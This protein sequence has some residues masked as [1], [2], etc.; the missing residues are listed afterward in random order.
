MAEPAEST[1]TE[2]ATPE[3]T[4]PTTRDQAGR[5]KKHKSLGTLSER[6][7]AKE[8]AEESAKAIGLPEDEP[9]EEAE[10]EADKPAEAAAEPKPGEPPKPRRETVET[11]P[12]KEA[13]E[14]QLRNERLEF[15]E[16]K[17]KQREGI[18][19]HLRN[20]RQKHEQQLKA[21]RDAFEKERGEFSPRVEKGEKVLK[22]ME[23]ADYEGLAKEAGY[24]DWDKFQAHVLGTISDPNYRETRALRRELEERKA[25]EKADAEAAEKKTKAEQE[26]H[27]RRTHAQQQTQAVAAH[28][29]GLSDAMAKSS[30]RLVQHMA[31]DPAFLNAVFEIQR[32]NYDPSTNSTVTPEQ[33]CRMALRGAPRTL[34]EEV[35]QLRDRLNKAL[36][37]DVPAAPAAAAEP[38]KP[39]A[40]KTGVVPSTA[41]VEPAAAGK[42]PGGAKGKAWRDYAAKKMEEQA[43]VEEAE[44]LKRKTARR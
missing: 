8:A 11:P 3:S 18:E 10:G 28:K 21:E 15:S 26:E 29:K 34:K 16:W 24:E 14:A 35:S 39:K 31:D 37:E 7:A 9:E 36:G 2:T 32:Q 22:L 42:W 41:T 12:T 33:A 1:T 30:D 40:S 25:K 23:S 17:R 44:R 4:V 5:F 27:A 13:H 20:E 43:E 6:M 19:A 38:A